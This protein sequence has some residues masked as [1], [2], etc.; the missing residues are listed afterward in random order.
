[1]VVPVSA[2][3]GR[4]VQVSGGGGGIWVQVAGGGTVSHVS[5]GG[6]GMLVQAAG[7]GL[8]SQVS[9]GGGAIVVQVSGGGAVSQVSCGGGGILVQASGGGAVS[10][11]AGGDVWTI[12]TDVLQGVVVVVVVAGVLQFGVTT[13]GVQVG[14]QVYGCGGTGS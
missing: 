2:V 13:T 12:T 10:Q 6:D 11:V 7:G 3:E 14:F 5:A 9:C 8:V 4:V 1:M